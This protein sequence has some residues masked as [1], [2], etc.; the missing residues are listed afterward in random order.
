MALATKRQELD[1]R[2]VKHTPEFK[3]KVKYERPILERLEQVTP[4]QFRG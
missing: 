2:H 3:E 1:G 4:E